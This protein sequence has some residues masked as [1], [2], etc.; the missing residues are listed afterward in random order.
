M[1]SEIRQRVYKALKATEGDF[2]EQGITYDFDIMDYVDPD[3]NVI[4]GEQ[5]GKRRRELAQQHLGSDVDLN[6]YW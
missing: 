2:L 1:S 4:S 5:I 3:G 6:E